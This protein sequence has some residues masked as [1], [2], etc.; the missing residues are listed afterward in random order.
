[1]KYTRYSLRY[2]IKKWF[3]SLTVQDIKKSVK[4]IGLICVEFIIVFIGFVLF[5][6]ILALFH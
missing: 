4:K 6:I 3:Y 2:K 5:V 1:M